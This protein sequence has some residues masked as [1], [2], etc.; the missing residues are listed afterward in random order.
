[1]VGMFC[2]QLPFIYLRTFSSFLFLYMAE[3]GR[4]FEPRSATRD[5]HC[6]ELLGSLIETS[7]REALL[8]P[9]ES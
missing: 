8:R 4:V 9:K 2:V 1:M 5:L 6:F 7:L 3:L